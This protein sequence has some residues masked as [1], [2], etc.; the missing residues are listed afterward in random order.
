MRNSPRWTGP[1]PNAL[2]TDTAV[3]L[4]GADAVRLG[5]PADAVEGVV[6]RVIVEP[7][8]AEAVGRVLE[9]ASRERHCVLV[10][11]SGT[12]LG[13][14]EAPR[15]IDILMS[16]ARQCGC[17]PSPWGFDRDRSIRCEAG[18]CQSGA[19]AASPVDSARSAFV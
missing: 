18:R 7:V 10:R 14:G 15:Q 12:K 9:W 13:W 8:S 16:T 11:G 19:C 1:M 5:N 3:S 2:L 4:L 6:P 17:R